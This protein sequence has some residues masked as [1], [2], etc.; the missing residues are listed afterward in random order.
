MVTQTSDAL[1]T[2]TSQITKTRYFSIEITCAGMVPQ[3]QYNAYVDG[4][5]VNAFCK[6]FGGNLGDPLIAG[7]NGQ[8]VL[9]YL[10]GVPYNQKYVTT[11]TSTTDLINKPLMITFVDPKGRASTTYLPVILKV[12]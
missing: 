12:V 10:M 6:P 4:V 11:P 7:T 3:T 5:L 9:Q 8:L 1:T 2:P